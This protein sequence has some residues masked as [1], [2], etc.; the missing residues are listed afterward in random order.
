MARLSQVIGQIPEALRPPRNLRDSGFRLGFNT[1]LEVAENLHVLPSGLKARLGV[2]YS[3]PKFNFGWPM[4]EKKVVPTMRARDHAD[5]LVFTSYED[6]L[7]GDDIPILDERKTFAL[8][9][10]HLEIPQPWV[11]R[12]E[13]NVRIDFDHEMGC[14]SLTNSYVNGN[15]T[16]SEEVVRRVKDFF[17]LDEEPRWF[18]D[19]TNTVWC[20][21][22]F[23]TLPNGDLIA[24]DDF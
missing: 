23:F 9:Q 4:D 10:K 6:P 12:L 7:T 14:L 3:P 20:P 5:Y 18:L 19:F 13:D 17:G 1:A 24:T 21:R 22:Y 16:P 11:L 15:G 2:Y 8:V